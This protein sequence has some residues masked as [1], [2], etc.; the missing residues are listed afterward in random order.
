M[1]RSLWRAVLL[2]LLAGATVWPDTVTTTDQLSV[3]GSL[4]RLKD[5]VIALEARFNSGTRTVQVQITAVESIE[6][7][8]TTFNPG[9]PPK[10][11]GIGPPRGGATAHPEAIAK[12]IIVL[13]GGERDDCKLLSIDADA[14]Y[15]GG[16]H[17]KTHRR[18]TVLRIRVGAAK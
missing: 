5:G 2:G 11:L 6:F 10:V 15:C 9:A 3:N 7:N 18:M 1:T 8:A 4:V 14:V 16:K 13:R 17:P 12:D